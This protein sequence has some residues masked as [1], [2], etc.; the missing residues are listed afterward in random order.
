VLEGSPGID[1]GIKGQRRLVLRK[2][3]AVGE[4]G[5]L[6]LEMTGIGQEDR[7]EMGSSAG[8]EYRPCKAVLDQER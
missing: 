4:L 7:A 1:L 8:G 6:L 3:V 2:S 5:V